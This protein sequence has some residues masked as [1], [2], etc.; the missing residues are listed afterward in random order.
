MGI[1]NQ[2]FVPFYSMNYT[3]SLKYNHLP[4]AKKLFNSD[5]DDKTALGLRE[6]KAEPTLAPISKAHPGTFIR[7]FANFFD[8]SSI[9]T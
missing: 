1:I 7:F 9:F 8:T 3:T 4:V 6:A 5:N 2:F